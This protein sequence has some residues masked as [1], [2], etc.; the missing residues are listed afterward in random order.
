MMIPKPEA[1]MVINY[2]YLW[3][4]EA[5]AGQEEGAKNRPCAII[6]ATEE[7]DRGTRVQILPVTHSPPSS[8]VFAVEIPAAVK[9]HLKL[10]DERSWILVDEYN[11]FLWPGYDLQPAGRSQSPVYGFLPQRFFQHVIESFL[12][13][14]HPTEIDRT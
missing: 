9:R 2:S 13:R 6:L 1:G 12:A 11:Q 10:D 14:P 3:A 8:D 4:R 7:G 5:R